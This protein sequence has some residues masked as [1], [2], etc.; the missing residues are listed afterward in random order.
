MRRRDIVALLGSAVAALPG[1][2][3][4]QQPERIRRIGML[5][6]VTDDDP[7]QRSNVMAFRQRL[8]TLG[9]VEGR[10]LRID[11]RSLAGDVARAPAYA[12]ELL[13]MAPDVLVSRSEPA[14]RALMQLTGSIPIVFTVVSEPVANGF[15]A[16]LARP[17]R[18]VTGFASAESVIGGKWLELL[19]EVAPRTA[20]VA[21]LLDPETAGNETFWRAIAAA[22]STS[23]VE[24]VRAPVRV[25]DNVEEVI[26]AAGRVD[27]LIVV[28]SV[29]VQ[30]LRNVIVAVAARRGL[31][32]VYAFR[33]FSVGGG[34]MSYGIDANELLRQAADYA[35]RILRGVRPGDLP[36]QQP[37][38]FELVVNLR[39]ARAL[40]LAIPLAVLARADEVID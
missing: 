12:A 29:V 18:N 30:R 24:V 19:K 13:G 38:K 3:I 2:A 14:L 28:P 5:M 35:D 22:A 4:A 17:G 37:T 33:N 34:L 6:N 7:E 20:R 21:A 36:V 40:G 10:N 11:I 25:E 39:T 15:V 32:A 1:P 31:P 16:S 8:A 26:G 23:G 27:G 9:W